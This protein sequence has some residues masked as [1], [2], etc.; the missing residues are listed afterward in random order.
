MNKFEVVLI[1]N[2]DLATNILNNELD[3]LSKEIEFL[4]RQQDT[5]LQKAIDIGI[6]AVDKISDIDSNKLFNI[7]SFQIRIYLLR[8]K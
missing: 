4:S 6:I 3:N 7:A 1:F 5:I 8:I 2:P